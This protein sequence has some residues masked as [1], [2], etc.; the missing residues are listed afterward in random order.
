MDKR[1]KDDEG[2]VIPTARFGGGVLDAII[3]AAKGVT[4]PGH[5]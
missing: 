2:D 1:D 4:R 5:S 3:S